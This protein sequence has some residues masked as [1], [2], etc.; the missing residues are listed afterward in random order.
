MATIAV[1]IALGGGA[2]AAFHLPRDSVKSKNIVDG[3]VKD[4][5]VD[6][7]AQ[8]WHGVGSGAP[9]PDFTQ[10][11]TCT[12]AN[13]NNGWNPTGFIRDSQ[14][15]VHLRGRVYG[16]DVGD[17]VPCQWTTTLSRV[18]FHLPTGFRPSLSETMPLL[19]NNDKV[20][21]VYVLD[22]GQVRVE[23][24]E[25]TPEDVATWVQLDGITFR[26][27]PSGQDGCP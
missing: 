20:G 21:Q 3:Q 17:S 13:Y 14:G 6:L 7:G 23:G 16:Y 9:E 22:D 5:D 26:C 12:W 19:A 4:V 27:A 11:A 1:F 8:P 25:I 10:T 2:Y 15:F 24:N 18:I